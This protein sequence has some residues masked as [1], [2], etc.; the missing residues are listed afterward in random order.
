TDPFAWDPAVI[1]FLRETHTQAMRL[2][3]DM[4]DRAKDPDVRDFAK[5]QL[6]GIVA[7][8]HELDQLAKV[9]P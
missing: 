9:E 5:R 2:M 4:A 3:R 6:P 7:T 8:L 1:A